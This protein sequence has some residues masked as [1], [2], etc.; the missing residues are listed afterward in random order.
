MIK[1]FFLVALVFVVSMLIYFNIHPSYE[2]SLEA[3]Y[4]FETGDYKEA[5]ERAKEAF[6]INPY[7]KMAATI[8]TQSQYAL[9]YV[10]YIDN[11]KR[12]IKEMEKLVQ[13]DITEAKRAKIRTI[14]AIMID[15]YKKLVPSVA[16]DKRL[17]EEAKEYYGKFQKLQKKARKL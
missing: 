13:E 6:E 14:S 5:Y 7:N 8:M 4:Y 15:S 12:Y 2:K 11:A 1:S 9:H 10:I 16:I 3:K 17:I